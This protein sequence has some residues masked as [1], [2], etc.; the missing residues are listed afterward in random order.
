MILRDVFFGLRRFEQLC[1]DLR[2]PTNT[3]AARLETLVQKG[4]LERVLY[5]QH[6]ARWEYRPTTKGEALFP[7]LLSLLR[8]GDTWASEPEGAPVQVHH[9]LCGRPAHAEVVCNVCGDPL[10]FNNVTV[11]AGPGVRMAPGTT[12]LASHLRPVPNT[13]S[14]HPTQDSSAEASSHG[15]PM[16]VTLKPADGVHYE[17]HNDVS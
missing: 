15:P 5:S 2:I 1:K 12:L 17:Q 10:R 11:H 14:P 4:V 16:P 7:I 9:L 8:W 3:L 6:P 13:P